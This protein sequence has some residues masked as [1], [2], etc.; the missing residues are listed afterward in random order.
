[1]LHG[2]GA[3]GDDLVRARGEESGERRGEC[4]PGGRTLVE[5]STFLLGVEDERGRGG[6]RTGPAIPRGERGEL[7]EGGETFA[8]AGEIN[9]LNGGDNVGVQV[10]QFRDGHQGAE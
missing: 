9:G 4:G 2:A 1:M 5:D 6:E 8:R 3:A 10:A 7:A